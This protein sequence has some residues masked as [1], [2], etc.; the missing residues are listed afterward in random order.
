[1]ASRAICLSPVVLRRTLT[2]VM[3]PCELGAVEVGVALR[4][5]W[6]EALRLV[7]SAVALLFVP[8]PSSALA[9]IWGRRVVG[10]SGDDLAL[11]ALLLA[12]LVVGEAEMSDGG[13]ASEGVMSDGGVDMTPSLA[14]YQS[15]LHAI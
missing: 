13:A 8:T 1:M 9:I 2:G 4:L 7:S 12:G 10:V 6:R 14:A 15:S 3:L 11:P 5:V